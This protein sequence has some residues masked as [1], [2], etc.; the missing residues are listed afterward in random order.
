MRGLNLH[1]HGY[2]VT[3][4]KRLDEFS[5]ERADT[6]ISWNAFFRTGS[7][8]FRHCLIGFNSCKICVIRH[9]SSFCV[10]Q[11]SSAVESVLSRPRDGIARFQLW[12]QRADFVS[13]FSGDN[14]SPAEQQTNT[15]IGFINQKT[16]LAHK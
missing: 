2:C 9:S 5:A 13:G 4:R 14:E 6:F 11:L 10:F 7:R 16:I 1:S 12:A 3:K 8:S 15:W